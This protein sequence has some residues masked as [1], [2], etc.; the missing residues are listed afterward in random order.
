MPVARERLALLAQ[1]FDPASHAAL[2]RT[3]VGPGWS[4]WEVGAGQGTIA[5]WLQARVGA[6]GRV[7]ASDVDPRFMASMA[8]GGLEVLTHDVVRDP[9]PGEAFD[10]VHTRLLLCHLPEREAVLDGLVAALRPGGWLVVED[11]DGLS[12]PADRDAN[13]FET[14]LAT[15]AALR[16]F[17]SRRGV[18]LRTGRRLPGMLRARGLA[19]VHA[20]GRVFM[21]REGT[22]H[23]RFQRLTYAQVR[24]EMVELGLVTREQLDADLTALETSFAGPSPI[25]WSAI[26]RRRD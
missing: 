12:M 20:E 24:A 11:F 16:A 19:D 9:P 17:L 3:G 5:R 23:A 6:T 22:I 2:E 13:P 21:V 1:I 8:G 10:L 14:P 4:C 25:L 7:V 18:D 26:G 15:Q